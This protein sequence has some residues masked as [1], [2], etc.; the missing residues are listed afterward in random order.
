M[1]SK[2]ED[3]KNKSIKKENAPINNNTEEGKL[4]ETYWDRVADDV[5]AGYKSDEDDNEVLNKN[6]H[7][8]KKE[9][10]E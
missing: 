4:S 6:Q 5:A 8:I 9:N 2:K 7:H 3:K 10:E 1:K